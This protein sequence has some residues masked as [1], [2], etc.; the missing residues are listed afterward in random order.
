MSACAILISLGTFASIVYQNQLLRKQQSA[1]VLPYLEI[2]NSQNYDRYQLILMNNGIGPAF[3]RDVW[4][5]YEDSSYQMDPWE[6]FVEVLNPPD[7]IEAPV[8][9]S[10]VPAGRLVPAGER[11]DMIGVNNN[12]AAADFLRERFGDDEVVKVEITFESVYGE[13]WVASGL[14]NEPIRL[15]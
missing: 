12:K 7:S 5:I 2:W 11:I 4:V 6:A 13:R 3:I 9:Y 14:A 8:Y 10:N 15:N 1:T